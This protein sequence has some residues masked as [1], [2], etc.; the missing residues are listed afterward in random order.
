[1]ADA[2]M[3]HAPATGVG[4]RTGFRNDSGG[5]VNA[6]AGTMNVTCSPFTAWVDGG[7]SDAQGGYPVINDST[8]TLA[9]A[10][11]DA[12][13]ARV[14]IVAVVIN[15]HAFDGSG[16]TN[17]TLTVIQGTPGG[18]TPALPVTCAP[19]RAI[20]IP[21]GL[22]AGTGGLSSG[23]MGTDYRQYL[24]N[25]ILRVASAAERDAANKSARGDVVYRVDLDTL[26]VW[27]GSTWRSYQ[28]YRDSYKGRISR[29]AGQNFA[30]TDQVV[31]DF[32]T[33]DYNT[34]MTVSAVTNRIDANVDAVYRITAGGTW[35]VNNTGRRILMLKKNGTELLR[36]NYANVTNAS[37]IF[38]TWE[39]P[40]VAGDQLTLEGYQDSGSTLALANAYLAVAEVR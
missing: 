37:G 34:G 17:C 33:V 6:V 5:I 29:A 2:T 35:A 15:D 40:L 14:D 25:G 4:G 28:P 24:P 21:A 18:G 38:L 19:I 7:T 22:S 26:E 9:I 30:S 12:T 11:G 39:G 16:Q 32:S 20:N 23:N 36:S 1:M 31:I 10:P 3:L 8:A 27:N 13:Q